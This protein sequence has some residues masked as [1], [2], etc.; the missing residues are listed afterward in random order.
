M[1]RHSSSSWAT[2]AEI[3]K[4]L[5]V[6]MLMLDEDD[7]I[8]IIPSSALS[9]SSYARRGSDNDPSS[10]KTLSSSF[11]RT[12]L[13]PQKCLM[14]FP[15]S[16]HPKNTIHPKS[17]MLR[18]L[19]ARWR[20]YHAASGKRRRQALH[21][22]VETIIWPFAGLKI[23]HRGEKWPKFQWDHRWNHDE[24]LYRVV[25]IVLYDNQQIINFDENGNG[26]LG[27]PRL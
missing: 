23:D 3:C 8:I 7:A 22:R 4:L 24:K 19:E 14:I 20:G 13:K 25:V 18:P 16:S 1:I 17:T 27:K 26:S 15:P 9:M 12:M 2:A 11:L 5:P 21:R 6:P 10:S